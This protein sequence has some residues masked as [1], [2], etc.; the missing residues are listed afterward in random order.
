MGKAE[1]AMAMV[2]TAPCQAEAYG[3]GGEGGGGGEEGGV[4]GGDVAVTKRVT[5]TTEARRQRWR[6][7]WRRE[8]GGEG[9]GGEGGVCGEGRGAHLRARWLEPS[10]NEKMK[11]LLTHE[12]KA[13]AMARALPRGTASSAMQVQISTNVR[14]RA[15]EMRSS[16]VRAQRKR[17]TVRAVGTVCG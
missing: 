4:G 7:W 5:V 11:S 3:P 16:S 6:W 1:A 8:G 15:Q 17:Q 12:I 9:R 2:A 14:F 13:R 10:G